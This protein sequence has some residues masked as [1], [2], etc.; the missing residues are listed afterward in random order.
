M[1]HSLL[2]IFLVSC[3]T[4]N[5]VTAQQYHYVS[6]TADHAH[7]I[8]VTK[9]KKQGTDVLT[10]EEYKLYSQHVFHPKLGTRQ[11]ELRDDKADHNF[12]A[13][14]TENAIHVKGNF[15][16]KP[17][18]KTVEIDDDVWFNKLDHG[19]SAFAVSDQE[20][21]SFWVLKLLSDLDAIKM[22][23]EKE[24]TERIRIG[25]QAYDAVKVKLTLDH[26]ILSKLWAAHCWYRASDGLFLRYE[27]ANG[28][29][30]TPVTVIELQKK[31][32]S[33][34]KTNQR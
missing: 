3:F 28:R 23:A 17:L 27:G 1:F 10:L 15:H 31:T 33:L 9:E 26:F 32:T 20:E 16:G 2:Y 12:V 30:G 19:L 18:E 22:T 8:T 11:W 7:D 34:T 29:P 14:R 21:L 24:G 25:E 6:T 4:G 5:V 13:K